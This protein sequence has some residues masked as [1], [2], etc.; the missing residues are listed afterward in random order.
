MNDIIIYDVLENNLTNALLDMDVHMDV[1][2]HALFIIYLFIYSYL[3][4]IP[5]Q[6]FN[7]LT[8]KERN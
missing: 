1:E 7:K 3:N 4:T 5:Y 6:L 8:N 2:R